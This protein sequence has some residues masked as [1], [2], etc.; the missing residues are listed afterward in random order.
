M[1][2]PG[3]LQ[4]RFHYFSMSVLTVS[5]RLRLSSN[6]NSLKTV[7]KTVRNDERIGKLDA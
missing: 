4:G 6:K 1:N 3:R 2:V 7:E 5:D